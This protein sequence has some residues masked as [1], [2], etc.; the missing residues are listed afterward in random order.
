MPLPGGC[1]EVAAESAFTGGGRMFEPVPRVPP[2]DIAF[3]ISVGDGKAPPAPNAPS[4]DDDIQP[5][6]GGCGEGSSDVPNHVDGDRPD[7]IPSPLLPDGTGGVSV[8]CPFEVYTRGSCAC[9]NRLAADDWGAT[10]S[11]CEP[12]EAPVCPFSAQAVP[13][14]DPI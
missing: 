7:D 11:Y 1:G 6:D 8:R 10:G 13:E 12:C 2:F 9:D 4:G 3:F 5:L 14:V